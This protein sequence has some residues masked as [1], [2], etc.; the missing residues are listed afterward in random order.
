MIKK[1]CC[2]FCGSSG[3]QAIQSVE[4]YN[5]FPKTYRSLAP[6]PHW[7]IKLWNWSGC[8]LFL[9]S[10]W[11][12]FRKINLLEWMWIFMNNPVGGF[13]KTSAEIPV[14][15]PIFIFRKDDIK[16]WFVKSIVLLLLQ[17]G[18]YPPKNFLTTNI[19]SQPPEQLPSH[20]EH[21]CFHPMQ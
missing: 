11:G 6:G 14:L 19:W 5:S 8:P 12:L 20:C 21:S 1:K 17:I 18:H 9:N 3:N 16:F 4:W 13:L 10:G 15:P 7:L 2:W